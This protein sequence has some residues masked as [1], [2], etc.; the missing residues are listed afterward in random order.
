MMVLSY[1]FTR[2]YWTLD[3][4]R[5]SNILKAAGRII[6]DEESGLIHI[7][8]YRGI[9]HDCD[10]ILWMS[11]LKPEALS[12]LRMKINNSLGGYGYTNYGLISL[13]ENSPYMKKGGEL[14][15]TLKQEPHPYFVAYPMSKLP[16]W[17]LMDYN[18]RK[19]IMAEH[20]GM[21]SSSPESRGIRSYTTYSHGLDDQE[22]VVL[23]EVES[24]ADWSH[25][26][27]KLR[28]ARARKWI[29]KETPILTGVYVDI[30]S[31]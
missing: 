11:S 2:E 6:R 29:I 17:Y 18:E 3:S 13:Y 20:I 10:L 23:Y 14:A 21:A 1:R 24:L 16:E 26:T 9:R 12:D 28:E 15:D 30:E 25:V 31:L 22:F 4:Y 19:E 5:R 8:T 7:R 27:A